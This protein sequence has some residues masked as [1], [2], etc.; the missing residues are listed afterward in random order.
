MTELEAALDQVTEHLA[1]TMF[2]TTVVDRQGDLGGQPGYTASVSF[3]GSHAG[4]VRVAMPHSTAAALAANFL[5]E[6]DEGGPAA[7]A[8]AL[9]GELAN[10][11]CGSLAG[12]MEP[13]GRFAIGTPE[14]ADGTGAPDETADARRVFTL[15]EGP[16]E[17][18]VIWRGQ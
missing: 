11:L 13:A 9:V 17:I 5:G 18:G 8:A 10:I 2:F 6:P 12:K 7:R 1:E 14:V 16:L 3:S 4:T 15:E